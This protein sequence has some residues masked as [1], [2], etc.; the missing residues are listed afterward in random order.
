MSWEGL[1]FAVVEHRTAQVEAEGVHLAYGSSLGAV[2]GEEGFEGS[3]EPVEG[4]KG[5][6]WM[7]RTKFKHR[8]REG[9]AVHMGGP[10]NGSS[11]LPAL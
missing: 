10:H 5:W 11:E 8:L 3:L 4:S 6:Q 9:Q 7:L 1:W 2:G